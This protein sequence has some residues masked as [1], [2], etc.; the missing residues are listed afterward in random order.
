M[1]R[2]DLLRKISFE[3]YCSGVVTLT[4]VIN[5]LINLGNYHLCFN[6][7]CDAELFV[8][9]ISLFLIGTLYAISGDFFSACSD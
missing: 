8:A 7:W 5:M 3:I 1:Q 4:A 6:Y 2:G 9:F